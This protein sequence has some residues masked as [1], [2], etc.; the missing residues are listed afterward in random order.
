MVALPA[1]QIGTAHQ[2]PAP[3]VADQIAGLAEY[4]AE[5]WPT[6]HGTWC[7]GGAAPEAHALFRNPD[8]AATYERL[9]DASEGESREARIDAVRKAEAVATDPDAARFRRVNL[10][11]SEQREHA[12]SDSPDG[13]G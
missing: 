13:Q 6:S 4:F 12:P 5:H 3:R 7:P 1:Q 2:Q 10:Y 11:P 8:L 9:A